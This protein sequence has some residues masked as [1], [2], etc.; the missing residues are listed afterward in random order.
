MKMEQVFE[1]FGLKQ[2]CKSIYR[3]APVYEHM[4]DNRRVVIKKTKEQPDRLVPL[5]TWQ[6]KLSDNDINTIKPVTYKNKLHHFIGSENW[7]IYPFIEGHKYQATRA[8]IYSAGELLG[9]IHAISDSVFDHGFSWENYN[10]EYY[11]DVAEDIE[12]ISER[13]PNAVKSKEGKKLFAAIDSHVSNRFDTLVT[14]K[15]PTA[16]C[17]WDYKASN[18]VFRENILHLIDTDNA[19][20]VPRIFDLALALLLFHTTEDAAPARVFTQDEWKL[21]LSGYKQHVSIADIERE[22]WKNMLLFV[23]VD[24]VLWAINDLG[25]DESNRQKEFIRSLVTF[26]FWQ[27]KLD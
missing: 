15:L 9:R 13:Y 17:T 19:G 2:D 26:N 12:I 27:Y 23:Y 18:L 24:E 20:K 3:Y 8:Q 21:F 22:C 10:D 11:Q 6:K 4:V 14:Q 5:I 25:E 1:Y 16:D 7:V